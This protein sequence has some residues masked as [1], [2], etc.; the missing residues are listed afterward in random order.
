MRRLLIMIWLVA[1][2]PA[3]LSADLVVMDDG[4]TFSGQVTVE[5]EIVIVKMP[6]GS[7]S[8][9]RSKVARIELIE[10]P[11]EKLAH[12]LEEIDQK[13]EAALLKVGL[14]ALDQGLERQGREILERVIGINGENAEARRALGYV[15]IDGKWHEY[16]GA[17]ELVRSK[18]EAG[19]FQVLLRQ[20]LPALESVARTAPQ[21]A[22]V[23]E[24]TGSTQL[25]TGRFSAAAETYQRLAEQGKGRQA[26]LHG[27]V[28]EI[29]R[30]NPDGMYVLAEA[31]PPT[32]GL[33]GVE[34]QVKAGP[35]SLKRPIVLEAALKDLARR[36]MKKGEKLTR[37]GREAEVTQPKLAAARYVQALRAFDV[38]DALIPDI[39]RSFRVQITRRRITM[40][41]K[42]ADADA[43]KFDK[44]LAELGK[45]DLPKKE[46]RET[47]VR[48][49]H[50]LN[51]LR[52]QFGDILKL[53]R[54]YRREL[55]LEV[56]WAEADLKKVND[57]RDVLVGEFDDA[58]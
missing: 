50:H 17:V 30:S 49:I 46:Y 1:A 51:S 32:A 29:L 35:A 20:V 9:P 7:L 38:A 56:Q 52:G 45:K 57:M 39:T 14:W 31:Y 22:K 37:E 25:R 44:E 26:L 43:R 27:A 13:N 41:R 53:A 2:A 23:R 5:G 47:V 21:R 4:R 34:P 15:K 6:Y 54:P 11:E 33:M 18:L 19:Q 40:I 42:A 48:L 28:A 36:R 10:T 24:L 8:L 58:T 16:A 55:L 12:R 3:M